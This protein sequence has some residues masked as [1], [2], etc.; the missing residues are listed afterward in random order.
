[1]INAYQN[2]LRK[3]HTRRIPLS[4][5]WELTYACNLSCLHCYASSPP[6]EN[7]L[8]LPEIERILDE[9][10]EILLPAGIPYTALTAYSRIAD[11]HAGGSDVF[12]ELKILIVS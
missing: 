4:A 1:M 11:E 12:A 3:A 10:I 9:C 8:G 5:H 6:E 2:I 7:E